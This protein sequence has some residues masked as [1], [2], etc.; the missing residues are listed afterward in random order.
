M[1]FIHQPKA[2][3]GQPCVNLAVKNEGRLMSIFWGKMGNARLK[4]Q[5]DSGKRSK[6]NQR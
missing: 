6:R 4:T 3:I 1:S 2:D 5:E